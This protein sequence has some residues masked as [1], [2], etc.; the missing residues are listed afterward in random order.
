M[1]TAGGAGCVHI[2]LTTEPAAGG[3][4]RVAN[5][6][7]CSE[8]PFT[9]SRL[10][11]RAPPEQIMARMSA[12]YGICRYAHLTAAARG[13]AAAGHQISTETL[14]LLHIKARVEEIVEHAWR[15]FLELPQLLGQAPLAGPASGLQQF[16]RTALASQN[17]GDLEKL[18]TRQFSRLEKTLGMAGI[19]LNK[20][21]ASLKSWNQG[22]QPLPNLFRLVA[23]LAGNSNHHSASAA[24]EFLSGFSKAEAQ[25]MIKIIENEPEMIQ[26]PRW[27]Q[28]QPETGPLG[29]QANHPWLATRAGQQLPATLR[30]LAARLLSLKAQFQALRPGTACPLAEASAP[31]T[32]HQF[33]SGPDTWILSQRQTA[34][35]LLLHQQTWCHGQLTHYRI[36][37]PT[38]W[39]FHPQGP[40]WQELQKLTGKNPS[41]LIQKAKLACLG[42]S[43]C[44]PVKIA[45]EPASPKAGTC[46][47]QFREACHA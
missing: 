5:A 4:L 20:E 8:R 21:P 2:H 23:A 16:A 29:Q 3:E 17:T 14:M 34:R 41:A 25:T 19:P 39:N 33:T 15:L 38:E 9:I 13:F 12:V 36:L 11:E 31:E 40:C 32:L 27:N 45:I 28:S 26:R 10:F 47:D 24:H 22:D 44:V 37:A 43:P 42:L 35:G 1:V 46:T 7:V 6:A 30:R 18:I